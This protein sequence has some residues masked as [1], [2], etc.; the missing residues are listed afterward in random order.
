MSA[1]LFSTHIVWI[2]RFRKRS[3][4]KSKYADRLIGGCTCIAHDWQRCSHLVPALHNEGFTGTFTAHEKITKKKRRRSSS[5]IAIQKEKDA[6]KAFRPPV[7]F[8]Q[9]VVS[10][11]TNYT[12][13]VDELNLDL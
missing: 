7:P 6:Q 4:L 1:I 2:A 9:V 8:T 10:P 11:P 13:F 3:E 12:E 5:E